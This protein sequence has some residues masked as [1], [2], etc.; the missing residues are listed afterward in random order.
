MPFVTRI[1]LLILF[2]HFLGAVDWIHRPRNR[3]F[4]NEGET[5]RINWKFVTAGAIVVV[6]NK[7]A[8]SLSTKETRIATKK[9]GF[10]AT[11]ANGYQDKIFVGKSGALRIIN[12]GISDEGFYGIRITYE[13][14]YLTDEVE[15]K[16]QSK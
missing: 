9:E 5:A 6:Y 15:I 4:I 1:S 10:P 16:I 14:G 11:I 3:L 8:S 13:T 12:A 7:K 2:C